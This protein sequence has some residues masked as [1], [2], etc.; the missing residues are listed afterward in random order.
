MTDDVLLIIMSFLPFKDAV[1]TSCLSKRWRWLWL[2]VVTFI[3]DGTESLERIA[4][5]PSLLGSERTKFVNEV[6]SLIDSCNRPVVPDLQIR[7][8]LDRSFKT[9][10]D[11]WLKFAVHMS[12]EN[13]ELDLTDYNGLAH[14]TYERYK[15][16][17][18]LSYRTIGHLYKFP[19]SKFTLIEFPSLRRLVLKGVHI[20]TATVESILENSPDL[21][22]LSLH[23]AGR[24]RDLYVDD[25]KLKLKHLEI[26]DCPKIKSI[27]LSS[28]NLVSFTYKGRLRAVRLVISNLPCLKFW[29]I[30]EGVIG[31]KNRVF[32]Q[33]DYCLSYLDVL[34]L[35]ITRPK[36]GLKLATIPKL[37]MIKKLKLAIGARKDN[38]LLEFTAIA[39]ACPRLEVFTIELQW[40]SPIK[41]RRKVRHVADHPHYYLKELVFVGYFGR[42]SDL[43]L[44]VYFIDNAAG[45][46]KIVI[47]PRG[48]RRRGTKAVA[49]SVTAV[50]EA[51]TSAKRQLQKSLP[52]GR[53]VDLVIL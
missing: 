33:F 20:T 47:D 4:E 34:S 28:F 43:E 26:V 11:A 32:S 48:S 35:E 36:E 29:D 41:S 44:V 16:P 21:E 42:V 22:T 5:K 38:C 40:L 19:W 6:N 23:D 46:R 2:H 18:R 9:D 15:F 27:Y 45:L 17:I 7:Y 24:L 50:E 13:L 3:F 49:A 31:L 14:E 53:A 52:G 39:K 8:D 30:G 1:A 37:P 12:V 10:I 51:R 25:G